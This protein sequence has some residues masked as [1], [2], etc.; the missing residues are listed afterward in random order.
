MRSNTRRTVSSHIGD[1]KESKRI[2]FAPVCWLFPKK[3]SWDLC[4]S[5]KSQDHSPTQEMALNSMR[6]RI[7]R[8]DR[9]PLPIGSN[10]A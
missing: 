3:N 1:R 6:A 5:L 7:S 9:W 8:G 2:A 10:Q 4:V